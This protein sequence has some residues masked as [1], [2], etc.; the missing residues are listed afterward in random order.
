MR[1]CHQVP[2]QER[3]QAGRIQPVR[4]DLRVG[5]Q[6][7]LERVSQDHFLHFLDLFEQVV[8]QAPVPARFE[9]RLARPFQAL[10]KLNETGRRVP[11]NAGFL[12]LPAPFVL[13]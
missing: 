12:Q 7:R 13:C 3:G 10:E 2:S 9:H 4:L 6:P 11:L 8:R 5:N 1:P